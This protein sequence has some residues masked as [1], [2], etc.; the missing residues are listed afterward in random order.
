VVVVLRGQVL[1]LAV[2]VELVVLEH[3]LE[4]HLAVTQQVL[5]L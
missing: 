2:A 5:V 3:H 4:Q 1:A